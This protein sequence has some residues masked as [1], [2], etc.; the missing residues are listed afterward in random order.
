M[1]YEPNWKPTLTGMT[2]EA[3]DKMQQWAGMD[4]AIAFHLIERHADGWGN[5][6]AMM[7]AW[8]RANGGAMPNA[9]FR[10]CEA[11]PLE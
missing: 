8:L 7:Q 11:V 10:G 1:D 2:D 4:G 9:E 3:A 6:A 5:I